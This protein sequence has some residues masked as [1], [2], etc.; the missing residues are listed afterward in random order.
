MSTNRVREIPTGSGING[1]P[2][3]DDEQRHLARMVKGKM[4]TWC[5][6]EVPDDHMCPPYYEQM[7]NPGHYATCWPCDREYLTEQGEPIPEQSRRAAS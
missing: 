2:I 5:G 1:R 7:D 3:L 6:L 4:K